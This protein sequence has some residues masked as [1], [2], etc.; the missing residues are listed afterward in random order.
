M[1][2]NLGIP[3]PLPG[4]KA[5]TQLL[6]HPGIPQGYSYACCSP[7]INHG[8]TTLYSCGFLVIFLKD[9]FIYLFM[10]DRETQAERE[11]QAPCREP[12]TGLHH[13][14]PGS[15]PGPKTG[16]KLLSH[17]GIPFLVIFKMFSLYSY[18]RTDKLFWSYCWFLSSI[19]SV[20]SLQNFPNFIACLLLPSQPHSHLFL[21]T[22]LC[23]VN[24][25]DLDI[26]VLCSCCIPRYGVTTANMHLIIQLDISQNIVGITYQKLTKN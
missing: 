3:G 14:S 16:A 21:F 11:K 19:C 22:L 17:P 23:E 15:S 25:F 1:G 5:D 4:L 24:D 18:L 2:L 13:G 8:E 20:L 7:Q 12:Y 6:S 9:L 26:L 10:R